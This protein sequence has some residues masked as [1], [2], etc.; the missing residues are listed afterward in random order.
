MDAFISAVLRIAEVAY[1][2]PELSELDINPLTV[3]PQGAWVLDSAYSIP[4]EGKHL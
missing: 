3:L 4:T 1:T 2:F